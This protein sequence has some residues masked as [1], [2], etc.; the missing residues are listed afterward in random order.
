[1]VAAQA[2]AGPGPRVVLVGKV[3]DGCAL[4]IDHLEQL[5]LEVERA[6]R[7]GTLG[8]A[9]AAA[10]YPCVAVPSKV[11]VTWRLSKV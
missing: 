1:V 4:E 3:H 8:V 2:L 6:R 9:E 7:Q 10:A 5:L 11:P